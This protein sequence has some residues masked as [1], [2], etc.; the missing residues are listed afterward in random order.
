MSSPTPKREGERGVKERGGERGQRE[1][2]KRE[3]ERGVKE[4]GGERK[5]SQHKTRQNSDT[6]YQYLHC[7]HLCWLHQTNQPC[8][9]SARSEDE[10]M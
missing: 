8:S 5:S 6:H 3:E 9:Q 10:H 1:R 4:R 2:S 7:L